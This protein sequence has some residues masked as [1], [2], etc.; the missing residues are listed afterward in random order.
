MQSSTIRKCQS[1]QQH[2][3]FTLLLHRGKL[4]VLKS[5]HNYEHCR[6][7]L[8]YVFPKQKDK[9]MFLWLLTKAIQVLI[10]LKM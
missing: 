10:F 9:K 4:I 2:C 8:N 3:Q 7:T 1:L 6:V 5:T